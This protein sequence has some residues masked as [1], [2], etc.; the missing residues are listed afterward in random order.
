MPDLLEPQYVIPLQIEKNRREGDAAQDVDVIDHVHHVLGVGGNGD[1]GG[2]HDDHV[3]VV[4]HEEEDDDDGH[5]DNQNE[6]T[7]E[8]EGVES[9]AGRGMVP[10]RFEAHQRG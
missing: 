7:R 6:Y 4:D 5:D 9:D 8:G 2:A 3:V 1:D 10:R